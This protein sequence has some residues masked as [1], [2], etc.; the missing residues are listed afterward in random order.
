MLRE[1]WM[2]EDKEDNYY[3]DYIMANPESSEVWGSVMEMAKVFEDECGFTRQQVCEGLISGA[4]DLA[5]KRE[6]QQYF[7]KTEDV[8][9]FYE[10]ALVWVKR[11]F[12]EYTTPEQQA[13]YEEK[14][15]KD[16]LWLRDAKN[17][18]WDKNDKAKQQ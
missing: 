12:E 17:F 7:Q 2:D 14:Y 11:R 16:P 18:G 1:A 3:R 15:G 13:A 10:W 4:L 5:M 9:R 6:D 8:R